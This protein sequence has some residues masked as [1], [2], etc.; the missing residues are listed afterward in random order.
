MYFEKFELKCMKMPEIVFCRW[1][2]CSNNPNNVTRR[3]DFCMQRNVA[4]VLIYHASFC[5]LDQVLVFGLNRTRSQHALW[6][7][8]L[9]LFSG[10]GEAIPPSWPPPPTNPALSPA[11]QEQLKWQHAAKWVRGRKKRD[12]HYCELRHGRLSCGSAGTPTQ[13][14]MIIF[15]VFVCLSTM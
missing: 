13:A 6:L 14:E 8:C 2:E 10:V 7:W 5:V 1:P 3:Y 11:T 9:R 12:A 15:G 4:L